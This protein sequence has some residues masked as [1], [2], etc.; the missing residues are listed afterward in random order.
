[1]RLALKALFDAL[2]LDHAMLSFRHRSIA[3]TWTSMPADCT[4]VAPLKRYV[5]AYFH[6]EAHNDSPW[7]KSSAVRQKKP[8]S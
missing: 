5:S 7:K 6:S 2:D 3:G 8:M 1:M 4:T